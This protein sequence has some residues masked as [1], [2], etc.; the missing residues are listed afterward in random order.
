MLVAVCASV[1]VKTKHVETWIVR[2]S[3]KASDLCKIDLQ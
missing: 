2:S 3:L 1:D